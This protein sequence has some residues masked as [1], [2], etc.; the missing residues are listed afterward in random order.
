M[1]RKEVL[2]KAIRRGERYYRD[3]TTQNFVEAVWKDNN[4]NLITCAPHHREWHNFIARK[5]EEGWRRIGILSPYKHGKTPHI[6]SVAL[7]TL[8]RNPEQ[9]ILI[10][11][12]DDDSAKNRVDELKQYIELDRDFNRLFGHKV[13]PNRTRKWTA[14]S[15]FIQ[16]ESYGKD[17]SVKSSGVLSTGIGMTTDLILFDDI[18]DQNNSASSEVKRKEVIERLNN[19]WLSRGDSNSHKLYIATAWHQEDATHHL[20]N[21]KEWVWLIQRISADFTHIEQI[22]I[23]NKSD[24]SV[25]GGKRHLTNIPSLFNASTIRK[26]P[27]W[28]PRWG[29]QELMSLRNEIGEKAFNR[30]YRHEALV[31]EMLTFP[32]FDN[33]RKPNIEVGTDYTDHTNLVSDGWRFFAGV[34]VAGTNRKKGREGSVIATVALSPEGIRLPVEIRAGNWNSPTFVREIIGCFKRYSHD[35]ILVESNG[36]Q[37]LLIDWLTQSG[38]N[39][40][41]PIRPFHTGANKANLDFG[42]PSMDVEFE[43]QNWIMPDGYTEGHEIG[44]AC[45]W[46]RW[47][48]EFQN[49][50]QAPTD[51]FVMATWFCREGIRQLTTRARYEVEHGFGNL[52][53]VVS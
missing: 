32:H 21:N 51:D 34:D 17:E 30:G 8:S 50:P 33:I 29:K 49:H 46:C 9:R 3:P 40:G 35:L 31:K 44:C 12:N 39:I 2:R 1:D 6:L 42:L 7:H 37:Q 41:L 43:H 15:F 52:L 16:R 10:V 26:I 24:G 28:E 53:S 22:E 11:C 45:H 18:C 47:I 36:V 23:E 14:H 4:N 13:R 27:L 25:S 38:M 48:S 5:R 19:V 20:L